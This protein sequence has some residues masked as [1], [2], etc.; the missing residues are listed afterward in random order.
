[1]LYEARVK[2][3]PGVLFQVSPNILDRVE[4]GRIGRKEGMAPRDTLDFRAR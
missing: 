4:I 3:R 2:L 1:M